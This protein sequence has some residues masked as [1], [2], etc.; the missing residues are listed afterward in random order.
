MTSD[1]NNIDSDDAIAQLAEEALAAAETAT[2]ELK[3]LQSP[4]AALPKCLGGYDDDKPLPEHTH[5][6]K[7][8]S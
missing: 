4:F 6:P 7:A 3:P 2:S 8:S 5:K 1:N